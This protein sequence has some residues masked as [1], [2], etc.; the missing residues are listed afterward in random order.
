[1]SYRP[2]LADILNKW[3]KNVYMHLS[4]NGFLQ[5]VFDT[6]K[7]SSRAVFKISQNSFYRSSQNL[8]A[9][10]LQSPF[11]DIWS[12]KNWWGANAKKGGSAGPVKT[13]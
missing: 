7:A 4:W 5:K 3:S 1:M 11:F 12:Q 13:I 2:F 9:K 6:Q 8:V 10:K